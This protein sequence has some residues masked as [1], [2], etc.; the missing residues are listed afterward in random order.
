MITLRGVYKNGNIFLLENVPFKTDECPVLITFI[1]E[2][3]NYI[4][5]PKGSP[6]EIISRI[7][8]TSDLTSREIKILGFLQKGMTNEEI[9]EAL[10]ISHGTTRNRLSTIYGKLKVNNRTEAVGKAI[11]L[12]ILNPFTHP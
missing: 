1:D 2:L 6:K 11:D 8:Q 5:I 4:I 3:Q 7:K 9:A 10:E 12:G